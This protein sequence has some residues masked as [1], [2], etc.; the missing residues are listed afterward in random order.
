ME[1]QLVDISD[2][3]LKK[4]KEWTD[5]CQDANASSSFQLHFLSIDRG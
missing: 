4:I 5:Q 3:E 1:A 2:K